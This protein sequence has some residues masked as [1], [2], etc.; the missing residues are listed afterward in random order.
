[1]LL[2][3]D[4][5]FISLSKFL[6]IRIAVGLHSHRIRALNLELH[7]NKTRRDPRQE[8]QLRAIARVGPVVRSQLQAGG[9]Q[10]RN[11]IRR[12]NSLVREPGTLNPPESNAL[13]LVRRGTLDMGVSQV[14]SSSCDLAEPIRPKMNLLLLHRGP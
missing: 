3:R 2:Q 8:C 1:M 12:T 13:S 4:C 11:S 6:C 5:R 7:G 14:S 9:I 10:V